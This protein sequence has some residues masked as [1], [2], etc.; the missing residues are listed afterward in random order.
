MSLKD[1]QERINALARQKGW[2][3]D[4][5]WLE[6]GIF[7]EVG[8]LVQEMEKHEDLIAHFKIYTESIRKEELPAQIRI[9]IAK[10]FGDVCFFLFQ[11]MHH[12]NIDLDEALEYVIKDNTERKKKTIDSNGQVVRK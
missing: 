2:S 10:E 3:D 1:Y 5:H 7:K 12:F 4:L 9:D 6:L 11:A 8:E